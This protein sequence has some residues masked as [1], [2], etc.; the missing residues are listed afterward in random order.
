MSTCEVF[1]HAVLQVRGTRHAGLQHGLI[2]KEVQM[3]PGER[4]PVVDRLIRRAT[5]LAIQPLGGVVDLEGDHTF[6]R[7]EVEADHAPRC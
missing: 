6:S 1:S 5:G 3:P 7:A 4:R 2:L